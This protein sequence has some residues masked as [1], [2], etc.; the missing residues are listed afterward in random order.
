M[1]TK[2]CAECGAANETLAAV[3]AEMRS[4]TFATKAHDAMMPDV[5]DIMC[6]IAGRL[7]AAA[8]REAASIE[9]LIRD[10]IVDYQEM[11]PH[12]PNDDAE[13]ELIDRA[14]RGNAW[15]VAYGYEPEAL[16]WSKKEVAA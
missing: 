8:K 15:L 9:R 4:I 10:A 7:E 6:E 1:S 3:L 5:Y 16:R 11:Y 13:R 14:K 2:R 12:S